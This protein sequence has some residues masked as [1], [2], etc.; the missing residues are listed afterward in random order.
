MRPSPTND[1]SRSAQ[2]QTRP[3]NL[4]PQAKRPLLRRLR[5]RLRP[6]RHRRSP[7][8]VRTAQRGDTA[9]GRPLRGSASPEKLRFFA[10]TTPPKSDLSRKTMA[11]RS[12][13]QKA[14]TQDTVATGMISAD[15]RP[16]RL[17]SLLPNSSVSKRPL[18]AASFPAGK[19]E[20]LHG[21]R[22]PPPAA[23]SRWR[24]GAAS[25]QRGTETTPASCDIGVEFPVTCRVSRK[26]N[27]LQGP[28]SGCSGLAG[29]SLL[30]SSLFI[31]FRFVTSRHT[32]GFKCRFATLAFLRNC[33]C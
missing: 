9:G 18:N 27:M 29:C 33:L 10:F 28:V 14:T 13:S 7:W 2:R 3:Q 21:V 20:G 4:P 15:A 8:C 11:P 1:T 25:L 32:H 23:N 17:Q 22:A 24:F 19:K 31:G 16:P 5:W 26:G 6:P 30:G 12:P